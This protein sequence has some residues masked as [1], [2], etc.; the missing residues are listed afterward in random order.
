MEQSPNNT[1]GNTLVECRWNSDLYS[2]RWNLKPND[3]NEPDLWL[4]AK[5]NPTEPPTKP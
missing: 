2:Y 3:P 4:D 5:G 1:E